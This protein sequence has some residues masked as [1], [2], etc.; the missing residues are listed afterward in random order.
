M[1]FLGAESH[2]VDER[3]LGERDCDSLGTLLGCVGGQVV[4]DGLAKAGDIVEEDVLVV[5]M[6][7][8]GIPRNGVD[9]RA[10]VVPLQVPA[11]ADPEEGLLEGD[12][13]T[14]LELS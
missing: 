12:V 5:N 9:V 14:S 6:N 13:S 2:H 3:L 1:H 4:L 10:P 7:G 11:D 8:L